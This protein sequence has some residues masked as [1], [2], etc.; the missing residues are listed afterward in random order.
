MRDL[1]IE[2]EMRRYDAALRGKKKKRRVR[3]RNQRAFQDRVARRKGI[4]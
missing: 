2:R 1:E 4:K 3:V